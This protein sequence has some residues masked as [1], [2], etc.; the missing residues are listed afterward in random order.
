MIIIL[1]VL[2]HSIR[3]S[4][5][6]IVWITCKDVLDASSLRIAFEHFP[7]KIFDISWEGRVLRWAAHSVRESHNNIVNRIENP[8]WS[9]SNTKTLLQ[10]RTFFSYLTHLNFPGELL[11]TWQQ[12]HSWQQ[13]CCSSLPRRGRG[14][15]ASGA[16]CML[17]NVFLPYNLY[18]LIYKTTKGYL[19]RLNCHD[20]YE[21]ILSLSSEGLIYA[22][23]ACSTLQHEMKQHPTLF[24]FTTTFQRRFQKWMHQIRQ[25]SEEIP[26]CNCMQ[27]KLQDGNFSSERGKYYLPGLFLPAALR[28]AI[29]INTPLCAV[30]F[31]LSSKHRGMFST[32]DKLV[33]WFISSKVCLSTFQACFLTWIY[34]AGHYLEPASHRIVW[35]NVL[36]LQIHS[37]ST[38]CA[39]LIPTSCPARNQL[40]YISN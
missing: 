31:S 10:G 21:N 27:M 6:D 11:G 26:L 25:T 20:F 4:F 5:Q 22:T 15:T 14:W 23:N 36:L 37:L 16:L 39:H 3:Q 40:R 17:E 29:S 13:D 34:Q 12:T 38:L 1:K 24:F 2:G 8:W 30:P 35:K 28:I 33:R 32:P 18:Q 19:F 9:S 7:M